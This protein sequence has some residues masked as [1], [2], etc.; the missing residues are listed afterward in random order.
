[1]IAASAPER[2]MTVAY[3]AAVQKRFAMFGLSERDLAVLRSNAAFAKAELPKLIEQGHARLAEWPEVQ[4]VLTDPTVHSARVAHWVRVASGELGAGY[5]ESAKKFTAAL[6]ARNMPGYALAICH[7]TVVGAVVRA[8][9][10]NAKP[11]LLNRQADKRALYTALNKA[12]WLDVEVLLETYAAERAVRTRQAM[13]RLAESFEQKVLGIVEGVASAAQQM[14][15][16]VRSLA[17]TAA[18]STETSNAVATAAGEATGNVSVVATAAEQLQASIQE[19]AQ[20][21]DGSRQVA[22]EAVGK[23]QA[24]TATIGSLAQAVERIGAVVDLISSIAGQTNLL[25]LNATIEAARAGEAGKGFAVVASEVKALANQTAKATEEIS[26]QINGMQA[27]ATQSV[28]AIG[29]IREIIDR[30]S[31][32]SVAVGAA[33]EEQSA[34]TKEIAR[35][36]H[37]VAAGSRQVS[38]LIATV[39]QDAA[40]TSAVAGQVTTATRALN[41]QAGALREAVGGFLKQVRG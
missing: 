33:V 17:D 22:T 14:D 40:G 9:K 38:E 37:Q 34:S 13:D 25:A 16:A 39:K 15:G 21:I 18:R 12:A 1:M 7:A 26:E 4:A 19:I 35:N 8:L 2:P 23:A 3:E 10:L 36:T 11:G 5:M 31:N 41:E 6:Y 28:D 32:A 27:I 29:Q 24:T 30:I 20:Q